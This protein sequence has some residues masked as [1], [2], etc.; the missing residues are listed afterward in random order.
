MNKGD[1]KLNI[2]GGFYLTAIGA[3]FITGITF[4]TKDEPNLAFGLLNDKIHYWD[5]DTG[6][7]MDGNSLNDIIERAK[8]WD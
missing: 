3:V 1:K 5:I 7:S 4:A 2:T 8:E 6:K